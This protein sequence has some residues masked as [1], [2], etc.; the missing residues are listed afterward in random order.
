M[1]LLYI[2]VIVIGIL[3]FRLNLRALDFLIYLSSYTERQSRRVLTS[4]S[5]LSV[6]YVFQ[7][8]IVSVYHMCHSGFII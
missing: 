5:W 6:C 1:S 4:L 7:L 8:S 2:V 3:A